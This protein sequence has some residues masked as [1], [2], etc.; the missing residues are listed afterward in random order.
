VIT[1]TP[2]DEGILSAARGRAAGGPTNAAW[3]LAATILASGMAFIDG[4]VVNVALPVIEVELHATIIEA[5]SIVVAFSLFLASLM[6]VG[7]SLGDH[8]GRKR[9]CLSGV[10]VFAAASAWSGLAPDVHHLIVARAVQGIGAALM[11]P[12]SLA[13]VAAS[14]DQS[15]RG[16]AI[17][18]WSGFSAV[19]SAIGPVLGGFLTEHASWRWIFFINIPI[20]VAVFVIAVR[21]VPESRDDETVHHLDWW[22]ALGCTIGLGGLSYALIFSQQAGWKDAGVLAGIGVGAAA[23]AGFVFAE[24]RG[25]VPMMPLDLFRSRIFSGVNLMTFLL[26]AA[27]SGALF[28]VPFDLIQIHH[29]TPT[30]AGLAL[31]PFV[32][33]LSA[34]SRWSGGLVDA[35]GPRLPLIVGPMVAAIGLALFALPGSSGSY[36]STFFPAAAVLGLGMAIAVAPLTTA[37]MSAV[38]DDR[39][40][41]GSGV[42]N[43]VARIAGLLAV[44]LFNVVA[45][46]LFMPALAHGLAHVHAPP[47]MTQA[48]WAQRLRMSAAQVPAHVSGELAQLLRG[49]VVSAFLLA[50]RAAM[51]LGAAM[52]AASA[53]VA[54]VTFRRA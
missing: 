31:L 37:V 16:K 39:V 18:I 6:L 24:A 8:F 30:F 20:A 38:S 40:G 19:T 33:L 17:G 47:A 3:I 54:A 12:N 32:A 11:M 25:R 44:A 49:A 22:G 15:S 34:L 36:W 48:M 2:C 53:V 9:M 52:A 45:A 35:Y 10:G 5:Q 21:H 43:A 4:T 46:A 13:I 1:R 27:L 14:F 50:F 26:Y 51:L 41:I 7:G 23:L 28:F 42:N 29:Y